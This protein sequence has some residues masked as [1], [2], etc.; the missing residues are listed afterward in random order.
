MMTGLV[1]IKEKSLHKEHKIEFETYK[2][3]V[4]CLYDSAS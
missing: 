1:F 3:Y 4:V 2:F